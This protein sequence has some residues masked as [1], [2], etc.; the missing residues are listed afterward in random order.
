MKEES[1]DLV[2]YPAVVAPVLGPTTVNQESPD[3]F[4]HLLQ[5]IW[6]WLGKMF[7]PDH[8]LHQIQW[9]VS[10]CGTGFFSSELSIGMEPLSE[11]V[12]V[13]ALELL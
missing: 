3:F 2:M 12:L 5:K 13:L 7:H 1:C 11:K 8:T 10:K 6:S 4:R 9:G